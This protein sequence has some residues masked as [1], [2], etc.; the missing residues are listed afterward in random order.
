MAAS[1][2]FLAVKAPCLV[3]MG[4]PLL[5]L[6]SCKTF[7]FWNASCVRVRDKV[8]VKERPTGRGE[9]EREGGGGE[10]E[11]IDDRGRNFRLTNKTP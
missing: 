3:A 7:P 11:L 5:R 6:M 10:R 8:T 2:V 1:C 9:R 4:K